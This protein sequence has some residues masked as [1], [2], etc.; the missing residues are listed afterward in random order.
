MT[1][2]DSLPVSP[3]EEKHDT[4][5]PSRDGFYPENC[6]CSHASFRAASPSLESVAPLGIDLM[7]ALAASLKGAS[8][9]EVRAAAI[10]PAAPSD[11]L[12]LGE[13]PELKELLGELKWCEESLA[14]EA[15]R[16]NFDAARLWRTKADATCIAIESLFSRATERIEELQKQ[17]KER[18]G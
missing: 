3:K 10:T 7:K 2:P 5:C 6:E 14:I 8:P 9:E 17:L 4:D 15:E 1:N 11:S 16:Q 13:A 12:S 18:E